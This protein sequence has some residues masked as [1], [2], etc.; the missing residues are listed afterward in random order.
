MS[1]A[2]QQGPAQFAYVNIRTAEAKAGHTVGQH[3]QP[4]ARFPQLL[5]TQPRRHKR[6]RQES[7]RRARWMGLVRHFHPEFIDGGDYNLGL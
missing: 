3:Y 4:W 2:A 1:F 7:K 5:G 6:D